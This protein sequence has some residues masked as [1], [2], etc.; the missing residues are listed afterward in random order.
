MAMSWREAILKVLG[1]ADAPLPCSLVSND[2][3]FSKSPTCRWKTGLGI[4]GLTPTSGT[5]VTGTGGNYGSWCQI[6][7][8]PTH[9]AV[10]NGP[11]WRVKCNIR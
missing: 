2:R 5:G 8:I 10:R 9:R 6:P 11:K 3:H 4:K 1:E 7:I